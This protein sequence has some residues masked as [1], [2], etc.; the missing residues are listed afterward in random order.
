VITQAIMLGIQSTVACLNVSLEN[1]LTNVTQNSCLWPKSFHACLACN[2]CPESYQQQ[3]RKIWEYSVLKISI[4][5]FPEC[6]LCDFALSCWL[7]FDYFMV[8]SSQHRMAVGQKHLGK[9]ASNVL[10][11][12]QVVAALQHTE[13]LM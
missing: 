6:I 3:H 5:I 10:I 7:E 9:Q 4:Y 12:G 2:S 11:T 1:M 13:Y 8:W